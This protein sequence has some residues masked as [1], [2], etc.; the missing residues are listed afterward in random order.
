MASYPA[1]RVSFTPY[2]AMP[3][4]LD[5]GTAVDLRL[6]TAVEVFF[7]ISA[8]S[9][10]VYLLKW[11]EEAN[12]GGGRWYRCQNPMPVDFASHG[13]WHVRWVVDKDRPAYY[14]LLVPGGVTVTEAFMQGIR[15]G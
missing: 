5:T 7:S 15:V 4:N 1:R 2:T 8:G 13:D 12:A 3:V 11:V 14:Q 10:D 6:A 9:G